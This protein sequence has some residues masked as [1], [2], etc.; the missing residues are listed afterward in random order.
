VLAAAAGLSACASVSHKIAE[1]ASQAPIIG[2]PENAPARPAEPTEFPA[3][4]DMPPPRNSVVLTNI[5]Q[6]KLEDDLVAARDRQQAAVGI[7]LQQK[8]TGAG[9]PP[10]AQAAA[11]PKPKPDPTASPEPIY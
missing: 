9:T 11:A 8:K 4:H 7:P 6:K 2:L 10:R 5:E 1:T 3:V